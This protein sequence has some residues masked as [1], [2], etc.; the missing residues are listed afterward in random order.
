MND[1]PALPRPGYASDFADDYDRWFAKPGIT[2]A[3]V[4]SLAAL[5]GLGRFSNSASAPAGW[6]CHC[7]HAASRCTAS[8]GPRRCCAACVPN[9]EEPG[10]R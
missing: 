1:D 2:G 6:P 8:T 10:S 7:G 3:T 4:E 9:R 5:T